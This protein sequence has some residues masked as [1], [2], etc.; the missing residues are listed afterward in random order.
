MM[1]DKGPDKI[2]KGT[3]MRP[4]IRPDRGRILTGNHKIRFP[5][6]RFVFADGQNTCQ[7]CS[8]YRRNE[9]YRNQWIL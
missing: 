5:K 3:E 7:E 9:F 6:S 2:G 1:S 4:D 8:G